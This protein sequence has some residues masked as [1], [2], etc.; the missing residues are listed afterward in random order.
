MGPLGSNI[1]HIGVEIS[2]SPY[3]AVN[4]RI[5]TRMGRKVLDVLGSDGEFVPCMHSVGM[6]LESGQKDVRWPCNKEHKYIVHY[7]ETREIWSYGSGYGGNAL[8]GKNVSRY[9]SLPSWPG[10]GLAGRAHAD[11]RRAAAGKG[12]N[13]TWLAAFSQRLRQDQFC[14]A[15]PAVEL[16][17][18]KVTTVGDDIAWIKPHK[19]GRFYA[20]NPEAGYFG[21]APGTSEHTKPQRHDDAEAKLHFHQCCAYFRR[22]RVVGRHDQ[23]TAGEAYRLA[24]QGMDT[25]AIAECGAAPQSGLCPFLALPVGKLAGGVLVMPSH[26]TSPSEVSATLVKMQ[27]RFSIVM[28]LGL[29]CSEVPGATPK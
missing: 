29:V 6:P 24:G 27:F 4:M 2:D 25:S 11:S 9:A 8:L 14:H 15:D 5:M 19:D 26:H 7:P 28:A 16:Q 3:V 20:I 17:G 22:R 18:W 12:R 21:V 1:A 10:P 23:D 13:F